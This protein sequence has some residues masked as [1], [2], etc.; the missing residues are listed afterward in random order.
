MLKMAQLS[1][2]LLIYEQLSVKMIIAI[3]IGGGLSKKR[4]KA[5]T[6]YLITSTN[7]A[8]CSSFKVTDGSEYFFD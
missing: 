8:F 1:K 5:E 2:D 4:A 6:L 3:L 7:W